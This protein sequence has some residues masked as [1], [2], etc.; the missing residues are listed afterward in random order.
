MIS[1]ENDADGSGICPGRICTVVVLPQPDNGARVGFANR[2]WQNSLP[3]FEGQ[4]EIRGVTGLPQTGMEDAVAITGADTPA[5]DS[6]MTS[7]KIRPLMSSVISLFATATAIVIA[8]IPA[9]LSAA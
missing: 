3:L 7:H 9:M 2:I 8:L 5:G 6:T 4:T 1:I